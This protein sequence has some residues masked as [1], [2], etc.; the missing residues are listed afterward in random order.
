MI[1]VLAISDQRPGHFRK[2]EALLRAL[3]KNTPIEVSW[4]EVAAHNWIWRRLACSLLRSQPRLTGK[5]FAN[6]LLNRLED[7][8]KPH[9]LI[10]ST[11]A[12]TLFANGLL[13]RQIGCPN[14]FIG[15][16]RKYDPS[17]FWRVLTVDEKA[18]DA[19]RFLRIPGVLTDLDEEKMLAAASRL[20][21]SVGNCDGP[22]WGMLVGGDGAG[23]RFS[24]RDILCLAELIDREYTWKGVRWMI[25]TSRRTGKAF[26]DLLERSV[27]P[28]A[29]ALFSPWSRT[30][31]SDY[32][33]ILELSESIVCTDDSQ[34]MIAEAI[35]TGKKVASV[36]PSN[37]PPRSNAIL[38]LYCQRG[39]LVRTGLEAAANQGIHWAEV[40]L[41]PGREMMETIGRL[42]L[43]IEVACETQLEES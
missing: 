34:M 20:K 23:Y 36:Y 10:V 28:K 22:L 25:T 19:P 5:L 31:S 35:A 2:T 15:G 9:N 37:A 27:N 41:G 13:A 1:R 39:F 38:D 21:G 4:L 43:D 6:A 8:Q 26:E 40:V 29:V 14:I 32:Y 3:G 42:V 12:N 24:P 18:G 30:S 16:L 17:L 33:G 7:R 11:G